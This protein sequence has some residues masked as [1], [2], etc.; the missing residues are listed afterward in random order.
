M[1]VFPCV[2]SNYR[3]GAP[4]LGLLG[5]EYQLVP[6]AVA[7]LRCFRVFWLSDSV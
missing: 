6:L 2:S 7:S 3:D 4:G 5:A 1:F